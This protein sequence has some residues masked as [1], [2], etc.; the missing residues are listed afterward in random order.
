MT[1]FGFGERFLVSEGI[2]DAEVLV[3]IQIRSMVVYMYSF[4]NVKLFLAR[5]ARRPT[6]IDVT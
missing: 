1:W 3:R 4:A 6:A 2:E 5:S